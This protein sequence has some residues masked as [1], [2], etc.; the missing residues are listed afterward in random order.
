MIFIAPCNLYC[1]YIISQHDALYHSIYFSVF[2]LQVDS[3][4]CP[5]NK[6]KTSSPFFSELNRKL[7]TKNDKRAENN[8][9]A[10]VMFH[11]CLN[12][13]LLPFQEQILNGNYKKYSV[14]RAVSVVKCLRTRMY[15]N[16]KTTHIKTIISVSKHL[17]IIALLSLINAGNK[18]L[19]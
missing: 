19:D 8:F 11:M 10:D 12:F 5:N 4:V 6:K 14:T 3:W 2:I 13:F 16:F 18:K 7:K 9:D 17:T 1:F 15:S